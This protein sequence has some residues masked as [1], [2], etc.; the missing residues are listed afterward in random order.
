MERAYKE[1]MILKRIQKISELSDI[2]IDI[3][4]GI[5]CG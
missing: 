1:N 3:L 2:I 4:F 5:L